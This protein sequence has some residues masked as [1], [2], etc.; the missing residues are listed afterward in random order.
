MVD[1]L[2]LDNKEFLLKNMSETS[3]QNLSN[4]QFADKQTR[5]RIRAWQEHDLL[6]QKPANVIGVEVQAISA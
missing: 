4:L 6:S 2:V 1:K 5:W 3:K